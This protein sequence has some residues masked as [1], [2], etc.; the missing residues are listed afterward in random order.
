MHASPY[1]R[2]GPADST[3]GAVNPPAAGPTD[4]VEHGAPLGV[5]ALYLHGTPG[6]RVEARLLADAARRAGVRLIGVDRP[7][8]GRA[9][10]PGSARL[11]A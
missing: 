4:R 1:V 2:G 7:G 3:G 9:P 5:P 10:L 8:F 6:S 11:E